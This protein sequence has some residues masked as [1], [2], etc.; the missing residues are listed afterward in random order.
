MHGKSQ[1]ANESFNGTIW[2][3]IPKNNFVTLPNLE[4]AVYDAVAHYNVRM[5]ASL[6]IYEKINFFPGVYMLK[7]FQ[8][9]NL[10]RVNLAN[11]QACPKNKLRWQIL[12]A[13]KM[14]KKYN[15]LEKEDH[16]YIYSWRILHI[17]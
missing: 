14:H 12:W 11:Q 13:E 7:G 16:I 2:E 10:K 5:K 4:F 6:L 8:K 15:L 3:R 17:F 9:S 1:N